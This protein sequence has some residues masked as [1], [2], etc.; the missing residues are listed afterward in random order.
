MKFIIS[1]LYIYC[2]CIA[3]NMVYNDDSFIYIVQCN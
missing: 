3:Y 2:F 1:A